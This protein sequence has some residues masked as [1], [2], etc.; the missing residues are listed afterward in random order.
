MSVLR[1]LRVQ[2]VLQV[3]VLAVLM[4]LMVRHHEHPFAPAPL[5]P[6]S[7]FSTSA[8]TRVDMYDAEQESI[9]MTTPMTRRSVLGRVAAGAAF[10]SATTA[11]LAERL[12]AAD[13][14]L[15]GRLRHSV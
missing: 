1:V 4:V 6:A 11:S 7:T 3:L 8:P 2:R 15:K 10:L 13:V 14:Q 9:A 12:A 5:A